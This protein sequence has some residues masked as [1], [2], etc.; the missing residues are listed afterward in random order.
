MWT[1]K[2]DALASVEEELKETK[3]QKPPNAYM[4]WSI[5]YIYVICVLL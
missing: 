5:I 2:Y 4:S 3:T 1:I